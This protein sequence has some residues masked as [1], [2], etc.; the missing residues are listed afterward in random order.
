MCVCVCVCVCV[1]FCNKE[2]EG[3]R[4][5]KRSNGGRRVLESNS[6]GFYSY[7][8][9][10]VAVYVCLPPYCTHSSFVNVCVCVCDPLLVGVE[11]GVAAD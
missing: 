4:G 8:H 9:V 3:D 1:C 2:R 6:R 7:A 10:A 11:K 5:T